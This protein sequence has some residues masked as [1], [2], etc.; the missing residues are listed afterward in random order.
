MAQERRKSVDVDES[1]IQGMI[2]GEKPDRETMPEGDIADTVTEPG[3]NHPPTATTEVLK[4]RKRREPKDYG[5]MFLVKRPAAAKKQTYISAALFSKITEIMAVV[6]SDLTLPTFLDNV[7]E[8]HL[9]AYKDE[10][11]ELYEMKTN[12]KPLQ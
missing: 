2:D 10:I 1:L 9:D 12:K 11:N 8:H 5:G 6:A 3:E 7:L 4:P